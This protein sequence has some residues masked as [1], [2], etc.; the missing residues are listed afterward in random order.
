MGTRGR[1]VH[2]LLFA[3]L[4][5]LSEVGLSD[6]LR[7]EQSISKNDRDHGVKE[8]TPR[9]ARAWDTD[10]HLALHFT[11]VGIKGLYV[12]KTAAF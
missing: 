10:P 7:N 11:T 8:N 5:S 3:F 4:C 9:L 2:Y 12:L 1:A 6:F